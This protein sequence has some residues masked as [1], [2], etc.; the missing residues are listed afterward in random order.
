MPQPKI[1]KPQTVFEKAF[2]PKSTASA[3]AIR[4]VEQ[5]ARQ[6]GIH[7][8]HAQCGHGDEPWIL[9]RPV[10][11]FHLESKTVYQYQGCYWHGCPRCFFDRGTKITNPGKTRE[12]LYQATLQWSQKLREAGFHVVE[13]WSCQLRQT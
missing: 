11:R 2:F 10:D 13:A 3:E 7:I 12:E 9:G 8:H 5:Q 4:W 6:R 1:E